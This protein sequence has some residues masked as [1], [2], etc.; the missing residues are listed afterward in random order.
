MNLTNIPTGCSTVTGMSGL[1]GPFDRTILFPTYK[2][3]F[4]GIPKV[5]YTSWLQ[6]L[7]FTI[8]A[9]DYRSFPHNKIDANLV[10]FDRIPG[11]SRR[12]IL[13]SGEWTRAVFLRDPAERLLSAYL[14]KIQNRSS[15]SSSLEWW[16]DTIST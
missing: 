15:S 7:R 2:L 11:R 4:C 14:D 1:S 12:K 8:G 10:R 9:K 3:A 5:A 6:F 16:D 13:R